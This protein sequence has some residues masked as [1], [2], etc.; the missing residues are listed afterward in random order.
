MFY[1]SQVINAI[2]WSVGAFVP[3]APLNPWP[4]RVLNMSFGVDEPLGREIEHCDAAL[5]DALTYAR[6]SGAVVIAAA[7]NE[8]RWEHYSAPAICNHVVKVA[9]TGPLGLR[10]FYSN[11]G[12]S[13]SF[14]APG[15]DLR[16][17][18]S[19]GILSTVNSSGGYYAS[20][21]DF[22]QG[23]SMAAPHASGVAGLIYAVSQGTIGPERVEQILYATTHGFGDS[24]DPNDSCLGV[25]PCGHGILDAE[26][27]VR[28]ALANYDAIFLAPERPEDSLPL[29]G[30][31]PVWQVEK[32]SHQNR[33]NNHP[34]LLEQ[35]EDGKIIAH[36]KG[37]TLVLDASAFRQCQVIGR[38]GVGCYY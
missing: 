5:Q 37:T 26:N 19:G 17:G 29:T 10:A 23:T 20:G 31:S 22:Y 36:Y 30:P 9:A 15:G 35:L 38:R 14:A 8:N 21:F 7:G 28:A 11:Y 33:A 1:E 3:G 24:M 12:P 27:A 4:A 18:T 13:I 34:P 32:T 16:Y 25:K 2:Y 6:I